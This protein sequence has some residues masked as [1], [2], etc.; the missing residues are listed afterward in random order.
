MDS[1]HMGYDEKVIQN[2]LHLWIW[3]DKIPT[4][5]M[6]QYDVLEQL[7]LSSS[8]MDNYYAELEERSFLRWENVEF[9]VTPA[10][11]RRMREMGAPVAPTTAG[12]VVKTRMPQRVT[13]AGRQYAKDARA[14]RKAWLRRNWFAGIVAGATIGLAI[15]SLVIQSIGLLTS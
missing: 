4:N 13:F 2:I 9:I 8:V 1:V 7:G 15:G 3:A 6:F 11:V 12:I 14:P 5:P 10:L